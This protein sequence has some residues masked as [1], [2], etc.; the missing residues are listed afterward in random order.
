MARDRDKLI[1]RAAALGIAKA[2][3]GRILSLSRQHVSL[4]A[5]T[6]DGQ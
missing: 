3:I 1:R 5:N 6:K 4:I 2:E